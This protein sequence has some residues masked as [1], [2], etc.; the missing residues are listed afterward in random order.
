MFKNPSLIMRITYGKTLGFVLAG[1]TFLL[2]PNF[3]SD[4]SIAMKWGFVLYYTIIGA[5]IGLAGVFTTVPILGISMPW[6]FRGLWIG[7]WMDFILMLFI[8]DEVGA[9][10]VSLFGANGFLTSPLWMILD[11]ALFGLLVDFICTKFAGE[12]PD[13]VINDNQE[14]PAK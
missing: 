11:G 1:A 4:L 14:S 7:G 5:M 10:L 8:Y 3:F 13:C 6:W 12:G 9:M 2:L